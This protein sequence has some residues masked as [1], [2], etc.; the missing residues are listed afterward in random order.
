M[1]L[2]SMPNYANLIWLFE[3]IYLCRKGET[4]HSF[5]LSSSKSGSEW[6]IPVAV[7][8]LKV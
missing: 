6:A 7:L 8:L 3:F 2:P 4:G 5:G 1:K